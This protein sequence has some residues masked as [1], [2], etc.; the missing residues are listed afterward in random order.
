M[1]AIASILENS[2]GVP[3]TDNWTMRVSKAPQGLLISGGAPIAV[4]GPGDNNQDPRDV[5][6]RLKSGYNIKSMISIENTTLPVTN[7]KCFYVIISK[8]GVSRLHAVGR[9]ISKGVSVTVFA[10][11]TSLFASATL[12]PVATAT[13]VLATVLAAGVWGRVTAMWIAAE[14]NKETDPVLH[15]VVS[16]REDAAKHLEEILK[17]DGLVIETCGHIIVNNRIICR[18]NKWLTWSRYIGLL[19]APFDIM[20]MA[21]NSHVSLAGRPVRTAGRSESST[22]ESF[23]QHL[24]LTRSNSDSVV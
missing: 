22:S 5:L 1:V 14:M 15:T 11:G 16:Q 23:T 13:M 24:L 3:F 2:A 20:K 9:V 8:D 7:N 17:L 10:F 21:R 18:K 4:P 12:M 19:A 6:A